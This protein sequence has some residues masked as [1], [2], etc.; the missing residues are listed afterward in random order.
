[1][2]KPVIPFIRGRYFQL[3]GDL[4]MV[5]ANV[6][7]S[8]NKISPVEQNLV[9]VTLKRKMDYSGHFMQEYIDRNKLQ[10]FKETS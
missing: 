9:P 1:M 8:L 5:S 2:L 3:K 7:E 10:V 4:I 6:V